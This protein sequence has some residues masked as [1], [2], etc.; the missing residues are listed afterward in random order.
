MAGRVFWGC[1]ALMAAS[2][3]AA[4]A[5]GGASS[6][7]AIVKAKGGS[8]AGGLMKA[9]PVSPAMKKF[10]GVP[11]ISR[12]EAVK[13]IW[14]YIKLHEL[15]NPANKREIQCDEKLKTI[16]AGKDK[17]GMLEIAKLLSPH[18]IKTK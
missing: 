14:D 5:E 17:V 10:L 8:N 6:V 13:K 9:L 11:E 15:Q 12:S 18:F 16:F 3:G 2:R 1:R 7:E 4:A